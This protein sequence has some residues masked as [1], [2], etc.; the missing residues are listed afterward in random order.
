MKNFTSRFEGI[1]L[2]SRDF[3]EAD[4]IL[5]I[6]TKNHGKKTLIARGQK[7]FIQKRGHWRSS[8]LLNFQL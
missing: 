3:K 1:I 2:S 8:T 5:S 7:T 6:F 4:R